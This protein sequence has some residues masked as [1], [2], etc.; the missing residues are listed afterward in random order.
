MVLAFG[1]SR[2]GGRTMRRLYKVRGKGALHRCTWHITHG[3]DAIPRLP[4]TRFFAHAG[5]GYLLSKTGELRLGK[6]PTLF[7]EYFHEVEA[8]TRMSRFVFNPTPLSFEEYFHQVEAKTRMSR[9]FFNPAPLSREE[10]QS[11]VL[12][13]PAS[14][15]PLPVSYLQKFR[16]KARILAFS[17]RDQVH[18]VP[19][20]LAGVALFFYILGMLAYYG[21]MLKRGFSGDHNVGLYRDTLQGRASNIS[22]DAF[23]AR[24][25]ALPRGEW[26]RMRRSLT[27][28]PSSTIPVD[29]TP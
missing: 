8:R 6:R 21:L 15:Q 19:A 24:I 1:S 5:R 20:F 22:S 28:A 2:I 12:L 17:V 16:T 11:Y 10:K 9:F 29:K 18:A 3:D 13:D 7:E 23:L 14:L 25:L 4:P 27:T 26:E